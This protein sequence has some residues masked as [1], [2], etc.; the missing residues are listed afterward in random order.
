MR[1]HKKLTFP[2][3]FN[4]DSQLWAHQ[5]RN[6]N[7]TWIGRYQGLVAELTAL[8]AHGHNASIVQRDS[9]ETDWKTLSRHL[10][11]AI[12]RL[13]VL[14]INFYVAQ[15]IC[16]HLIEYPSMVMPVK[17]VAQGLAR[18]GFYEFIVQTHKKAPS[19]YVRAQLLRSMGLVTDYQDVPSILWHSLET[20]ETCEME[21]LMASEALI[22]L[23]RWDEGDTH[24]TLHLISNENRPYLL[25]NLV[26][27]AC[28]AA[29]SEKIDITDKLKAIQIGDVHSIVID[30]VQ[31]ALCNDCNHILWPP[32]PVELAKYYACYYPDTEAEQ[33]HGQYSGGLFHS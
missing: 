24:R 33:Q 8:F 17:I 19:P 21:K 26:L 14:E 20:D 29:L 28:R 16:N 6:F 32:E 4:V 9:E 27:I 3:E 22:A 23:D 30:A 25:K 13:S 10:R 5:F 7:P 15:E 18:Q 1:P 2:Q 31:Y 12:F 11:F